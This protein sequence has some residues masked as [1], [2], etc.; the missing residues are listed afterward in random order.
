LG[1]LPA[2]FLVDKIGARRTL[3]L[4]IGG[5]VLGSVIVAF[6]TSLW[7]LAV[8]V[9][10]MGLAAGLYHPSGLTLISANL[11][12]DGRGMGY[13]GIAGSMGLASGNFI[14]AGIL[15]VAGW[16]HLFG[17]YAGL[18]V[19]VLAYQLG[20]VRRLA[21]AEPHTAPGEDIQKRPGGRALQ[22][23]LAL[24]VMALLGFSYRGLV[25][26]M[27]L[28]FAENLHLG[29]I[30]GEVLGNLATGVML[31]GGVLGQ[32]SGGFIT[33]MRKP[34]RSASWLASAACLA[35]LGGRFAGGWWTLFISTGM[36]AAVFSTQPITNSL[37][38]RL[39]PARHRGKGYGLASAVNFGFGSLAGSIGGWVA[40]N[41]GLANVFLLLAAT[42]ALAALAILL[43][44]KTGADTVA[45]PHHG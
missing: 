1:A 4:C 43:L 3:R 9:G 30:T 17:L 37:I 22:V 29:G 23:T 38:G 28:Y 11:K 25:V 32:F 6:S 21:L 36:A 35:A 27:P 8:G 34:L 18:G 10:L 19:I 44:R 15:A 33:E 26:F 14:G 20:G 41:T 40:E 13:H 2:G 12:R 39:M 31:L 5:L 42:S 7:L 45:E 16:P 24:A